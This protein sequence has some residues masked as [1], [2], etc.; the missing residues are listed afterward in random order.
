MTT[1]KHPI[2]LALDGGYV[3]WGD[4]EGLTFADRWANHASVS[5]P[6]EGSN[7]L[8]CL[9]DPTQSASAAVVLSSRTRRQAP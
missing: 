4:E 8:I 7:E 1:Y 5:H 9:A 6:R 3:Y 2:S